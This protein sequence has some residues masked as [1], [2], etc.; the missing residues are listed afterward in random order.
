[1][2][3]QFN[4]FIKY[5]SPLLFFILACVDPFD[6][7]FKSE[8]SIFIVEARLTN[9]TGANYA[10]LKESISGESPTSSS[11]RQ[12]SNAEVWVMED[13]ITRYDFVERAPGIY[14]LPATFKG[15]LGKTYVL[16]FRTQD[17]KNFQSRE[18]K[19]ANTIDII[20]TYDLFQDDAISVPGE[21]SQPGLNVYVD[22]Q[23]NPDQ[24]NYYLWDY[25][26]YERQFWC[27]SCTD[28]QYERPVG[29]AG[30]CV[31]FRFR[32]NTTF[33]YNC[34][35]PCWEIF[36]SGEINILSDAF[37]NGQLIKGKLVASIPI[38][39]RGGA[40]LDLKQ[41][42][43]SKEVYDYMNLVK[44]Q[45]QNTGGL[46]DTPPVTL[47]G[48]IYSPD[49]PNLAVAGYFIVASGKRELYWLNKTNIPV[50][51]KTIGLL[52]GR[53]ENPE[54]PSMDTTRPPLAPC[55]SNDTRTNIQPEGWLSL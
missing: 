24:K 52:G 18:E 33:D 8:S 46:A 29:S 25:T 55:V 2:S 51:V 32:R 26:L 44:S 50:G 3:K 38:Y 30:Q 22:F 45:G 28:G 21:L 27:I 20:N 43:V 36:K 10:E 6:K 35:A 48:N 19:L 31:P 7:S 23:D 12:V 37:S 34:D 13:G 39:S 11:F 54:P 16:H 17:G 42:S 1:M 9:E 53:R 41:Y 47:A 49:D 14:N 5:I 40:L 15:Q 4:R